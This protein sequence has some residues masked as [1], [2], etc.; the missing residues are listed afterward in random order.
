[1]VQ[2]KVAQRRTPGFLDEMTMVA[3]MRVSETEREIQSGKDLLSE[4][5]K[6]QNVDEDQNLEREIVKGEEE[7]EVETRK[8]TK[9]VRK[10][11]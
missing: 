3:E 8:G 10:K 4:K 11:L 5:G 7:A 1:M 6:D 9:K 2:G